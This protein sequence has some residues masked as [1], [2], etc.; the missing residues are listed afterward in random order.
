MPKYLTFA[1]SG[2]RHSVGRLILMLEVHL[3]DF[4][5]MVMACHCNESPGLVSENALSAVF[6]SLTIVWSMLCFSRRILVFSVRKK[7]FIFSCNDILRMN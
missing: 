7:I 6:F 5:V 1:R 4:W 2:A 3:W